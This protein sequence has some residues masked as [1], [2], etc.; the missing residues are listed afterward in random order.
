MGPA[1]P[2]GYNAIIGD[3]TYLYAQ[4]A[5]T[6]YATT[7]PAPYVTSLETDGVTWT[8]F[9]GGAQL[10]SDG[11]INM[12]FDPVNRIVYSSNWRAGVWRLKL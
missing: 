10:F 12:V 9:N 2:D 8:P 3:G 5:N 4:R 7:A 11:P 1:T 6:G